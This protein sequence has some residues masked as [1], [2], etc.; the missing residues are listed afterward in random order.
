MSSLVIFTYGESPEPIIYSSVSYETVVVLFM[1]KDEASPREEHFH[2]WYITQA[3]DEVVG[4]VYAKI[5]T[6]R[7]WKAA[8]VA[9]VAPVLAEHGIEAITAW[10]EMFEVERDGDV[11]LY[12]YTIEGSGVLVR[13][14]VEWIA[15]DLERHCGQEPRGKVVTTFAVSPFA[16]HCTGKEGWRSGVRVKEGPGYQIWLSIVLARAR[17]TDDEKRG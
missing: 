16:E 17:S 4:P 13:D 8:A 3:S 15:G 7:E 6:E 14:A 5:L 2:P 11:Y 1:R 10:D 12:S 9:E